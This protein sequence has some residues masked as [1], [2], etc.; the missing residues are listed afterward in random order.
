MTAVNRALAQQCRALAAHSFPD[1]HLDAWIEDA[2]AMLSAAAQALE[3]PAAEREAQAIRLLADSGWCV[4]K[5]QGG[6]LTEV[7]NPEVIPNELLISELISRAAAANPGAPWIAN[8]WDL[9]ARWYR[10]GVTQ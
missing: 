9:L 7:H 8:A 5:T 4:V 1:D 10:P 3:A 2:I 6:V